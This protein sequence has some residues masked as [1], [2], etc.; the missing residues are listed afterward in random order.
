MAWRPPIVN[1]DSPA[2]AKA[3]RPRRTA[4][5]TFYLVIWWMSQNPYAAI[6]ETRI[7]AEAAANV[8]NALLLTIR[9]RETELAEITDWY[10]RDAEGQ[11][12]PVEWRDLAGQIRVPWTFKMVV[13][14]EA[15]EA[16]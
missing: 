14:S 3:T 12:M 7:A 4:S 6:F 11:P 13:R 8:R 5:K 10:R 16:A 1:A 15:E 9:G 2:P